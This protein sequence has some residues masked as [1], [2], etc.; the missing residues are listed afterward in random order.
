MSSA[1][2]SA[3]E[4]TV[5]AN[6]RYGSS[7]RSRTLIH[8]SLGVATKSK[9]QNDASDFSFVVCA[10]TQ[11]GMTS[12]NQEWEAEL[13]YSRRAI[14]AINALEPRPLFCCVCG[15]LVDMVA[16]YYAAELGTEECNRVQDLQNDDWKQTWDYLHPDIALV[17]V[18]GNHD[19]GNRPTK[20]TI[21]RFVT[22]FGDD[23]LAFWT[24]RAYNIVL[25]TA[26]F[27]DPSGA[28]DLYQEQLSWLKERLAYAVKKR[29]SH[30]FVFGHHPWFLYKEDETSEELTGVSPHPIE[31]GGK[32]M[33]FDDSYFHIP[34]QYRHQ[35]MELFRS[36]NVTACF[37]GHFHQNLVTESSFGMQM[38][39]TSSLS[40]VFHSSGIPDD[41]SE[42][43]DKRGVRI[44]NVK[45]DGTFQH[46]FVALP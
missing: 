6:P 39:V 5:N 23:Y 40:M 2:V 9:S 29:A 20:A 3:S 34:C 38:I 11:I 14:Q 26:L 32:G 43:K 16:S 24:R 35:V 1:S 46:E 8:P 19:V 30:I 44:V 27:R 36:H 45:S 12:H 22:A 33:G 28:V 4:P 41:F 7:Q 25:N 18:C 42:P 17:C 13:H 31:W 10:D 37:S 21:E 15:D